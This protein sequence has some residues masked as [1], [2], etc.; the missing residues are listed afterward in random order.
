MQVN[1]SLSCFLQ[2]DKSPNLLL[3][4]KEPARAGRLS[5]AA[6]Q[7]LLHCLFFSEC[8]KMDTSPFLS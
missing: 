3:S 7:Y 5:A 4:G 6:F 2:L 1:L 8:S